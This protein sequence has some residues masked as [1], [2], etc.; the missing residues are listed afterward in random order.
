[1]S[2]FDAV[3]YKNINWTQVG[4]STVAGGVAGG[5]GFLV[6]AGASGIVGGLLPGA[7]TLVGAIANGAL[8]GGVGGLFGGAASGGTWQL[9]YN[10]LTPCSNWDDNVLPATLF[11]ASTGMIVGGVAGG[12]SGG[13]QFSRQNPAL[14]HNNYPKD[15]LGR[16]QTIPLNRLKDVNQRRLNYVVLEDGTLVVGKI[17]NNLPGGGHIDLANGRPVQAAGEF[18]V[19]NGELKFIDNTSG[20][21]QPRGYSAQSAA[22][23][24]FQ[25]LGFDTTGKHIEKIWQGGAW[26]PIIGGNG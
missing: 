6:G 21:Y 7:T 16:P 9:A 14:F 24:A 18:G 10:L 2:F 22:E 15:V 20:H 23:E 25:R 17:N 12:L 11:G 26:I 3:Y 4:A 1:M 5:A 8:I 13:L 19:V